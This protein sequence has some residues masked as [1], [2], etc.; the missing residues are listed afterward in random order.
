MRINKLCNRKV[1]DLA[2]ALRARKVSGTFEK[3]A[4][5]NII[6]W[7]STLLFSLNFF[8]NLSVANLT[9]EEVSTDKIMNNS[10]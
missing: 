5:E 8:I 6:N 3:R 4:P 1:P 9:N 7:K 2:I 10:D